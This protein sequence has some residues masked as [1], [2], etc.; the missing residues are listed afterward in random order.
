MNT[1]F[2]KSIVASAVLGGLASVMLSGPAAA[3]KLNACQIRHSYCS[4]RCIMN[5]NGGAINSCIQ[6][7]CNHQNPGCGPESLGGGRRG[8]VAPMQ[9]GFASGQQSPRGP[10]RSW[11]FGGAGRNGG[12]VPAGLPRNGGIVP[13]GMFFRSAFGRR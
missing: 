10:G 9:S 2:S 7:T 12:I 4:E 11:P 5:Y 3:R 13:G 1:F 6:R 8:L